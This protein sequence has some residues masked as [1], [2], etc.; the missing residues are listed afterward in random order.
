ML[1]HDH[2]DLPSTARSGARTAISD[3]W[4]PAHRRRAR[5]SS[6]FKRGRRPLAVTNRT[7]ESGDRTHQSLRNSGAV[8]PDVINRMLT[9]S[10][11]S[12]FLCSRAAVTRMVAA[13]AS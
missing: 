3:Y 4:V 12:Y 10:L 11:A 2:Q 6:E 1:Q 8:E 5:A 13:A 9:V 7:G